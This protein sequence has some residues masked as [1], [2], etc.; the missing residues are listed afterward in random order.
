MRFWILFN[1]GN[2][3]DVFCNFIMLGVCFKEVFM[4]VQILVIFF[5]NS[6][7]VMKLISWGDVSC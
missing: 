2:N 4:G 5:G 6:N 1:F 3:R 7:W